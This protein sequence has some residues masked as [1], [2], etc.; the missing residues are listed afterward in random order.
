MSF[1]LKMTVAWRR[2]LFFDVGNLR[3]RNP[4]MEGRESF[5]GKWKKKR[6]TGGKLRERGKWRGMGLCWLYRLW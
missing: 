6:E 1:S 2:T 3:F 4:L 5:G